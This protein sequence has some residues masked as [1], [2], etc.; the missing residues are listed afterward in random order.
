VLKDYSEQCRKLLR[1]A[2]VLGRELDFGQLSAMRA[3]LPDH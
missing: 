3:L 2:A 1:V